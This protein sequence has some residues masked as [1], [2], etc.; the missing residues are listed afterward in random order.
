MLIR[1][2]SNVRI[3]SSHVWLASNWV[4]KDMNTR[5]TLLVL[6]TALLTVLNLIAFL[7]LSES[8]TVENKVGK[9]RDSVPMMQGTEIIHTIYYIPAIEVYEEIIEKYTTISI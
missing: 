3:C 7:S 1:I 4:F 8:H 6:V 9:G 5:L 2:S